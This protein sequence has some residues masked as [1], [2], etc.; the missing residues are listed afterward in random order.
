MEAGNIPRETM[1]SLLARASGSISYQYYQYVG[2]TGYNR[3]VPYDPQPPHDSENPAEEGGKPDDYS[4]DLPEELGGFPAPTPG[5]RELWETGMEPKN[6]VDV[7]EMPGEMA[8]TLIRQALA[9]Q[10][11]QQSGQIGY[12]PPNYS[13]LNINP[14]KGGWKG[15]SGGMSRSSRMSVQHEILDGSGWYNYVGL[16]RFYAD[17]Y[18]L[19]IWNIRSVDRVIFGL[20][21]CK[22]GEPS[23]QENE[24]ELGKRCPDPLP[25]TNTFGG[26]GGGGGSTRRR[27]GGKRNMCGCDCETIA[28]LLYAQSKQ[29][30][31]MFEDQNKELGESFTE[32]TKFL[33]E[34]MVALAPKGFDYKPVLD[35]QQDVKHDIINALWNGTPFNLDS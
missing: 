1:G 29:I 15:D 8:N 26:G 12:V 31:G 6:P 2:Y 27:G 25:R 23:L 34:Q 11:A 30:K 4:S 33:Q 3:I 16:H 9:Q 24:H 32:Q 20:W 7:L 10:S 28:D 17:F 35:G 13:S 5:Q 21:E 14:S 22:D 18:S 19:W